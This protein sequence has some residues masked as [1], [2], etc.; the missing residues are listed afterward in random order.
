MAGGFLQETYGEPA[1]VAVEATMQRRTNGAS[2][3]KVVSIATEEIYRDHMIPL[4]TKELEKVEYL[5]VVCQVRA[6]DD[7][8]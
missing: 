3:L 2:G 5:F 1:S 4:R 8:D 6:T 7:D